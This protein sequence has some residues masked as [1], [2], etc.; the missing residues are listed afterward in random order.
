MFS[1]PAVSAL[2]TDFN[3]DRRTLHH[4][5]KFGEHCILSGDSAER[6]YRFWPHVDYLH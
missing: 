2:T 6:T 1:V 3:Q 4:I 5:G